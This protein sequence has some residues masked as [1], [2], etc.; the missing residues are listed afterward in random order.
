MLTADHEMDVAISPLKDEVI[1]AQR[2][3][4][5]SKVTQMTN[6]SAEV[7]NPDLSQW[8][9]NKYSNNTVTQSIRYPDGL[10]IT[11]TFGS[12]QQ[13]RFLAHS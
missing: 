8:E 7:K 13:Y 3:S 11:I 2:I 4:D 9:N 1:Q 10:C 12:E 6:G 5:L